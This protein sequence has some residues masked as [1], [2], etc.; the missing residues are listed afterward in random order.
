M[1]DHRIDTSPSPIDRQALFDSVNT[2]RT[3]L[4]F[5]IGLTIEERHIFPKMG[6]NTGPAV[7]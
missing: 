2:I 3:G 1:A 4:P 7:S 6:D 5:I